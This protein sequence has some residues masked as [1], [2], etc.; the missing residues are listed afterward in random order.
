M[1]SI[2][3]HIDSSF[4]GVLDVV[5]GDLSTVKT[6]RAK[7]ELV[8]NIPISVESY[9]STMMLQELASV[10]APDPQLLLITPWDKN[11]IEDIAKGLS[12]SELNLN[13]Q[14]DGSTIRIA[15]PTLTGERRQ[16]LAKLV[17]KKVE[18]GKILLRDER[19]RIKKEIDAQKGEAG[20]SEDDI[21]NA[22][23]ELDRKT[24]EWEEKIEEAGEVKKKE[25]MAV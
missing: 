13:P 22:V 16:E 8:A 4:S 2:L 6:G 1:I 9:G 17:D 20:V 24:K 21:F 25:V 11:I 18:S 19:G 10:T 23:E 3:Q 12:K 5:R 14:S 15:I 7:P